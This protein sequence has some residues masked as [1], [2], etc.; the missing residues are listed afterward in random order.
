[1]QQRVT[2]PYKKEP[3]IPYGKFYIN[4]NYV[5]GSAEVSA[6]N[7]LG[8]VMHEGTAQD[9]AKAKAAAAFSV[10]YILLESPIDAY[11]SVLKSVGASHRRDTIYERVL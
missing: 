8:V 5:D 6:D 10:V 3:S 7:W 1:M 2:N 11:Q 4:G 9:A